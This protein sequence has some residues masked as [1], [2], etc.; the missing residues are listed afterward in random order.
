MNYVSKAVS[1]IEPQLPVLQTLRYHYYH[2]AT[3][4]RKRGS[5]R[6]KDGILTLVKRF[7]T[8]PIVLLTYYNISTEFRC[9]SCV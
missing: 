5:L 2:T 4:C 1:D 3:K 8:T 6:Q 9:L 7:P